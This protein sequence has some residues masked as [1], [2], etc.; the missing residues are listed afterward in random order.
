MLY[1][2][3][4]EVNAIYFHGYL[5]RDRSRSWPYLYLKNTI[6]VGFSSLVL[7]HIDYYEYLLDSV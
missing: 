6:A 2:V 5:S 4:V 1:V 7:M 3:W